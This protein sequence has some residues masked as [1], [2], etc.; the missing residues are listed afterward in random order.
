MRLP[1]HLPHLTGPWLTAFRALWLVTFVLALVGAAWNATGLMDRNRAFNLA[2]YSLGVRAAL[3]DSHRYLSPLS[4]AVAAQGLAPNSR[5]LA[6]DGQAWP[7]RTDF[8]EGTR[9]TAALGGPEGTRHTLALRAPSGRRYDLSLPVR[10]ANFEEFE[11]SAAMPMERRFTLYRWA[12]LIQS[13]VSLAGSALLFLRR[14]GDPVVALLSLG[15]IADLALNAAGITGHGALIDATGKVDVS[16]FLMATGIVAFP[17]GRFEP[18][19]TELLLVPIVAI[20]LSSLMPSENMAAGVTALTAAALIAAVWVR[21]R[22]LGSSVERQQIKWA[23]LGFGVGMV[24]LVVGNTLAL[25]QQSMSDPVMAVLL[26]LLNPLWTILGLGSMVGGL[27]VSLLR[28]RLYDA[29][30]A[31]SRSALYGGLAL[32]MIAVFAGTEKLVELLAEQY[33]GQSIG[34]ASGAIAAGIAAAIIP[35][36]HRRLERWA[37]RRFQGPLIALRDKLPNDLGDWRETAELPELASDALARVMTAL[38]SRGGAIV[39]PALAEPILAARDLDP[40]ELSAWLAAHD[41]DALDLDREDRLLPLRVALGPL[42]GAG[43]AYLLL[44]PRPD[45]TMPGKDERQAAGAVADPLARALSVTVRR[46]ARE[47]ALSATLGEL[48][49]RLARLEARPA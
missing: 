46:T 21:Y 30:A 20:S 32:A 4:T 5:L 36:F 7:R 48:S 49:A 10:R 12:G 28:F 25:A 41:P 39:A 1:D 11:A 22:R 19:W 33:W 29:E 9:L 26:A 6:V 24:W 38:R 13:L 18:R 34:A 17:S 37:E 47:H 45:G 15:L 27:L 2:S 14:P 23:S 44:G 43:A 3:H 8:D 31:L 40:A 42:P 16:S 35:L